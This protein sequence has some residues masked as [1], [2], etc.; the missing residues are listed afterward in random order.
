MTVRAVSLSG[1]AIKDESGRNFS[2]ATEVLDRRRE[3]ASVREPCH[4]SVEPGERKVAW[5]IDSPGLQ[6][7]VRGQGNE[8]IDAEN[9]GR[10]IRIFEQ[11]AQRPADLLSLRASFV[12]LFEPS[13]LRNDSFAG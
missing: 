12:K 13:W 7:V 6:N 10:R 5:N 2:H 9:R 3:V 11:P 8:I 4:Y 1:D